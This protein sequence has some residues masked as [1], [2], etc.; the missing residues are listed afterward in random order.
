MAVAPWVGIAEGWLQANFI[1]NIPNSRSGNCRVLWMST[2]F[3]RWKSRWGERSDEDS[4]PAPQSVNFLCRS[5]AIPEE[6]PSIN[7]ANVSQTNLSFPATSR[8]KGRAQFPL[9]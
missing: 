7:H 2:R 3:A 4:N 5:Q 1:A 6:M 9:R 8:P